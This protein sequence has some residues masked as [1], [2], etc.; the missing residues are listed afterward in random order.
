MEARMRSWTRFVLA[1]TLLGMAPAYFD[2]HAQRNE[3]SEAS[4][5][6]AFLYKFAGYIEWP[7]AALEAPDAPFVIGVLG[8]D[9][10]AADLAK[11]LPGRTIAGRAAT[12]KRLKEGEPL[13]GVHLLFIAKGEPRLAAILRQALQ[14]GVLAVTETERGLELGSAINFVI[15]DDR[16][17]FE[18]SLDSAEKSGHKISSRMLAV[19]RRVLPRS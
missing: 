18:V 19:A 2:A 17:G 1:W 15:A 9:E 7:R 16:V 14:Q 6:A 5:K 13:K 12:V 3:A 8:S 10:V 11:V 4:V